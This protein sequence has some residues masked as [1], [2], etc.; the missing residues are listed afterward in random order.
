MADKTSSEFML[1]GVDDRYLRSFGRFHYL[2][3]KQVTRL[4][5]KPGSFTTV[6][7]RL[8]RLSDNEYLLPLALPT[9]RATRHRKRP[10]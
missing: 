3:A 9:I 2:T 6:Q 4:F 1:D 5:Y 7:A 10:Q 8:K